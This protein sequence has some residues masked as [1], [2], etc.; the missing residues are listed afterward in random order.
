M[1]PLLVDQV[2]DR[3]R[4]AD[5]QV[6]TDVRSAYAGRGVPTGHP[7]EV[8]LPFQQSLSLGL[9]EAVG[10]SRSFFHFLRLSDCPRV[11]ASLN[12]R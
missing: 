8:G 11:A 7:Q 2:R 6:T 12:P 9:S 10:P 4:E 5:V 3:R 1:V